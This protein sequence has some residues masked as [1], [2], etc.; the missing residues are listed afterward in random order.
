MSNSDFVIENGVLIKYN[1]EECKGES[2]VDFLEFLT[3]A[4]KS[5]IIPEGITEIGEKAFFWCLDLSNIILPF[6]ITKIGESAFEWCTSLESIVIP[7]SVTE[8]DK[9]AFVCCTNLQKVVIPESVE[10]IGAG[11]FRHCEN[12]VEISIPKKVKI[13]ATAFIGCNKLADEEGFIIV[14]STLYHYVGKRKKVIIPQGVTTIGD[15]ALG[16]S[17]ITEVTI[18]KSVKTIEDNAF[19]Y[20][21]K[22]TRIHIPENVTTIGK[23]AFEECEKLTVHAP[24]GS[25]AEQYAKE[26]NIP[27]VAE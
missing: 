19:I 6:G 17:N 15:W 12:L 11:A 24:A 22:L 10:K 23:C 14:N 9:L 18:P 4:K 26:N 20:C 25:Y 8:I 2:P 21:N 1:K 27:F 5:V 7:E 16:E 13:G 3:R